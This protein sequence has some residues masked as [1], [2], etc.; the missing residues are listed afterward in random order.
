MMAGERLASEE[1]VRMVS[2]TIEL[3]V[4]LRVTVRT[5]QRR[6]ASIFEVTGVE[7]GVISGHE[8]LGLEHGRLHVARSPAA[9]HGEDGGARHRVRSAARRVRGRPHVT[10][11]RDRDACRSHVT[12]LSR[13]VTLF[14]RR[15]TLRVTPA[16]DNSTHDR[17]SRGAALIPLLLSLALA[18]GVYLTFEGL[19]R[20]RERA[21][22]RRAASAAARVSGA[23]RPARRDAARLRPLFARLGRAGGRGGAAVPRLGRGQW[24]G[25]LARVA[26]AVRLLHPT[27]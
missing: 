14:R 23:R 15:V 12:L 19:V 26:G 22:R 25:R 21:S 4:Q 7:G 16:A 27:P 5:G 24:A 17:T 3:V 20:P 11:F 8:I 1:L 10:R 13:H 6:V 9:L 18:G 2:R